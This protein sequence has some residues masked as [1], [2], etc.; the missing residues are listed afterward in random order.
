MTP[1][2]LSAEAVTTATDKGQQMIQ[3]KYM[4]PSKMVADNLSNLHTNTFTNIPK[5]FIDNEGREE[6]E[7]ES[8]LLFSEVR[9]GKLDFITDMLASHAIILDNISYVC[10]KKAKKGTHFTELTELAIKSTDQL[11]KTGLALAQ[12]KNVIVNIENL[13]IQQN[14]LIQLN[15]E[16]SM[17]EVA[18]VETMVSA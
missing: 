2:C 16:K 3:S 18:H 8:E 10:H 15:A 13:H 1:L 6:I 5:S 17:Q 14:N 7:K 4:N 9:K 11:R 12:I